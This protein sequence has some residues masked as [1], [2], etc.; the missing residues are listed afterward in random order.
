MASVSI[1]RVPASRPVWLLIPAA[2]LVTA[3]LGAFTS[4]LNSKLVRGSVDW[5]AVTFAA[6]LWLVF[7][8]LTPLVYFL[9]R[10]Y[11]LRRERLG[12]TIA[13]HLVGALVLCLGWTS[14]GVL[15]ARL[16]IRRPVTEAFLVYYFSWILTNLPWSVFL[17]FTVLGC[18]FAF[19]YYREARERE[20]QQARLAAQLAEARL[21]ALRMQL[22]P[23]FLFNSLNAITVLVRDQNTRAASRMLELLSGVLRQ[24]LQSERRQ[25]VTLAEELQFIEKYL[26]IEQVRFP[27][28]LAVQWSIE[29]TVRD[30]L[31]PEFI[32]QPLVENAVRHGV[33]KSSD[34]GIIEV[35]AR[36]SAGRLVLSVQDNG[37]GYR[38]VSDSGVGLANTRARLATLFSEAGQLQMLNCDGG[39][40]LAIIRFPLRR[41]VDGH[42]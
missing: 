2:S 29:P 33:A 17:Y 23:H 34:A 27:D 21:G 14:L 18:V 24:V 9:A 20:S 36:E 26:A 16:L 7:G 13:V 12:H 31:V 41:E 35:A 6:A 4:Y 40:T 19:T 1:N 28:R 39:G 25:Q 38:P 5:T 10:R 8:A 42:D 32:L 30:A 11:P 37:P 15:L 3:L 22:N